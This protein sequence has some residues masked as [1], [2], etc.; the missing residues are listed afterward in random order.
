MLGFSKLLLLIVIGFTCVFLLVFS[1]YSLFE[2]ESRAF[3]MGLAGVFLGLAFLCFINFIPDLVSLLLLIPIL[4]IG[5]VIPLRFGNQAIDFAIPKSQFDERDVMFSRNA[6]KKGSKNFDMY[7]SELR[8]EY[9]PLDDKFRAEPG[10]MA[11]GATFYNELQFAAAHSTFKTVDLLQAQVEST[12]NSRKSE[13]D[14]KHI[15]EFIRHW[16]RKLGAKDVGFTVLKSHHIYSHIG[17]GEQ[18]GKEVQ[19]NHKYAIAFTVEMDFDAMTYNPKGPVVMESAQQYLQAGQIAV[20]LADFIR[21][22]GYE[23]RAHID[24]N[25]RLICPIIAEDA[26]LGM[27]GRM[28]LLMSPKLGPRVRIGVVSTNLNLECAPQ[29]KDYS[30]I[31]FCEICKKCAHNCPS[32]SIPVN[33]VKGQ[34]K[35]LKWSI[36][37]ESCFTYWCKVG[38]DCG[39]CMAVCPYSH[40]DNFM[41]SIVRWMIR[42]NPFNRRLALLLDDVFYGR[43][44]KSKNLKS[45]MEA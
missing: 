18:Y 10:L 44:P 1:C 40:P 20:Q 37:H 45:W 39:R 29:K 4:A 11:K 36:N 35:P 16:T 28:G 15:G 24:A 42:R 22:L 12:A 17:R 2:K 23:A 21:E 26:G 14:A 19:L 33:S 32:Q 8:P 13:L 6:L 27:V 25:Y 30:F 34:E 41:H 5:I 31:H 9:K 38:T 43:K 3:K 7:Y